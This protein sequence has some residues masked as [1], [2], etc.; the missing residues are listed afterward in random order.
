MQKIVDENFVPWHRDVK[1]MTRRHALIASAVAGISMAGA[2]AITQDRNARRNLLSRHNRLDP[3][4]LP[5]RPFIYRRFCEM[6]HKAGFDN[7][8][9]YYNPVKDIGVMAE[10]IHPSPWDKINGVIVTQS[11]LDI[12]DD[13]EAVAV[14]GHEIGHLR[15]YYKQVASHNSPDIIAA[16]AGLATGVAVLATRSSKMQNSNTGSDEPP[17]RNRFS[18]RNFARAALAGA[19]SYT[20]TQVGAKKINLREW[21]QRQRELEADAESVYLSGD[22]DAFISACE[23]SLEWDKKHTQ[24]ISDGTHPAFEARIQYIRNL[25]QPSR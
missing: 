7:L 10:G 13:R 21:M 14:I 18:R 5:D 2:G 8:T 24:G 22:K 23:K 25:D 11:M 3:T 20:A 9:L 19:L 16:G 6:A 17:T 4:T 15:H 12:L 1:L